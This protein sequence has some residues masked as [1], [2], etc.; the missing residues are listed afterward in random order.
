M[1]KSSQNAATSNPVSALLFMLKT[2]FISYIISLLLLFV[3]ALI[4]TYGA[5]SDTAV[6]I[7]A[8][9]VTALGTLIAGFMAG[10]HFFSKGIFF[11]AGCGIIYTILLCIIGNIFSGNINLGASFLTA[12]LIGILCGAV[13]GIA[14]INTKRTRRR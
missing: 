7:L 12:L 11:G 13:G 9:I 10:R 3:G 8:N 1:L 6:R 2:V 5:F 14:G 4:A